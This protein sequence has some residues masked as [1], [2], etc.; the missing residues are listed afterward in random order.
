M[1]KKRVAI[2]TKSLS[3]GGAERSAAMLSLML[4]A[5][6]YEVSFILLYD[7]ISFGH[8]GNIHILNK[9]NRRSNY[10]SKLN[11][12][13]NFKRYVEASNFDFIID[14]RGRTKTL[15][16]F[17][18]Y[19]CIYNKVGRII[20]TIHSSELSEFIPKPFFLF[21]KTLK[22]ASKVVTVS[23]EM[24]KHLQEKYNLQNCATINNAIDFQTI[25]SQKKEEIDINDEFIL[26][27]GRLDDDIKQIE[28]LIKIYSKTVLKK[29]GIKLY[30]MGDGSQKD[31]LKQQVI[32][33]N[34][35]DDVVFLPYQK[36]PYKYM[37]KS[38]FLV[39]CSKR[40]GFP[41]VL[42]ES[43]ACGVP[44]ISF[45]CFTGPNEIISHEH[46][47]LLVKNQ[48]FDSLVVA[49]DRF[50]K[51]EALLEK[52]RDNALDS[53]KQFDFKIIAI[54]WNKLLTKHLN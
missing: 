1:H 23:S 5:L 54:E 46:N 21:K 19:Q 39:L 14:F 15:R 31:N 29:Y 25:I 22:A 35:V 12:F 50:V 8:S 16:E 47:G 27:V 45:D 10:L 43:L 34:L 13:R 30:I 42:L 32:T 9:D 40:E 44:V 48:D 7:D 24:N 28:K 17:L 2:V 26:A 49:I 36:N 51:D 20:F 52:C 41:F 38:K 37:A 4:D 6:D 18:I 11:F 3:G 53:V 33:E